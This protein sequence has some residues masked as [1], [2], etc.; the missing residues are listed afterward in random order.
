MWWLSG[1]FREVNLLCRPVGGIDDLFVH[2]DYDHRTGGATLRVDSSVAAR[3]LV[4]ELD[5]D[6]ATG[7][8]LEVS[9]VQPWSAEVPRLYDAS[10][11]SAGE[12]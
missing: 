11:A 2:A 12:M 7:E 5:I 9:G 3:V 1:I 8:P 6:V 10:V 4:P